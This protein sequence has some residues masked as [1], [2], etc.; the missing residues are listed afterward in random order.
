MPQGKT[1]LPYLFGSRDGKS[2]QRL[3]SAQNPK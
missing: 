3:F 1:H 2:P